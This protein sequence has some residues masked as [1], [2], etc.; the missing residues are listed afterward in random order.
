MVT[1]AVGEMSVDPTAGE[2]VNFAAGGG[3]GGGAGVDVDVGSS[4]VVGR[5]LD[6]GTDDEAALVET[7]GVLLAAVSGPAGTVTA[8]AVVAGAAEVVAASEVAAAAGEIPPAD[9][10]P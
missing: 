2:L 1:R 10:D 7:S 5:T 8:A 9:A 4:E 3:G 6:G